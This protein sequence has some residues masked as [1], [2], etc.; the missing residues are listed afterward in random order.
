MKT[1]VKLRYVFILFA[2]IGL[3]G[4]SFYVMIPAFKKRRLYNLETEVM[5]LI[6]IKNNDLNNKKD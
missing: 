4:S 5:N 1:D 2:G 6:K 3:I